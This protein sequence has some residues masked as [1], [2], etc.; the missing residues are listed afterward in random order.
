VILNVKLNDHEIH[1]EVSKPPVRYQHREVCLARACA[2][3]ETE[4][5]QQQLAPA[6]L[7]R[8]KKGVL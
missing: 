2:K 6:Q 4:A 3:G 5:L 1:F 7:E 8:P